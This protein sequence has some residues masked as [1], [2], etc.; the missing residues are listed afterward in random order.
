MYLEWAPKNKKSEEEIRL[1]Q[2]W[3]EAL[4]AQKNPFDA[5]TLQNCEASRA[6]KAPLHSPLCCVVSLWWKAL[7]LAARSTS[8]TVTYPGLRDDMA[9][10]Q[11]ELSHGLRQHASPHNYAAG[12]ALTAR[13]RSS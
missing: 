4:K 12:T 5:E 9:A 13:T 10:G 6:V 7:P 11:G 1:R 8:V 3:T 2:Q